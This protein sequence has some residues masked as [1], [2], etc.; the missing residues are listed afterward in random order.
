MKVL[1]KI[2][3]TEIITIFIILSIQLAVLLFYI[4]NCYSVDRI[5][6]PLL[7][8]H[9][10]ETALD[11]FYVDMRR[12]PT[13]QENLE[14]LV[15]DLGLTAWQGPYLKNIDFL[16]PWGN[17]F[18]YK[19]ASLSDNNT[20]ILISKGRDGIEGTEDD[21]DNLGKSW[22][23]YY[24]DKRTCFQVA[25]NKVCQGSFPPIYEFK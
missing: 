1:K 25:F 3:L 22:E 6:E 21:I 9:A 20:Y 10:F 7:K 2:T 11:L 8:F 14:A 5:P 17:K 16:D 24:E 15:N 18:I 12:Y 4:S 19:M 23:K 13:T